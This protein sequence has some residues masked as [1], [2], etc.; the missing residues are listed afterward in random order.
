MWKDILSELMS[1]LFSPSFNYFYSE[2]SSIT[3]YAAESMRKATCYWTLSNVLTFCFALHCAELKLLVTSS[4]PLKFVSAGEE[5]CGP[6]N[7]SWILCVELRCIKSFKISTV[8]AFMTF[9][10]PTL[11]DFSIQQSSRIISSCELHC[12]IISALFW[13]SQLF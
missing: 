9:H 6:W 4:V 5:N 13:P 8:I 3:K 10:L 2:V 1:E 7:V 12:H 11:W